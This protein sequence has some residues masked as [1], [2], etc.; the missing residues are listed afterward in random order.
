MNIKLMHLCWLNCAINKFNKPVQIK[1]INNP[2]QSI[3]NSWCRH[4]KVHMNKYQTAMRKSIVGRWKQHKSWKEIWKEFPLC[5][6]FI[7]ACLVKVTLLIPVGGHCNPCPCKARTHRIYTPSWGME[8]SQCKPLCHSLA[9]K[10][11]FLLFWFFHSS[12]CT[13]EKAPHSVFL[14]LKSLLIKLLKWVLTH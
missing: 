1:N 12:S 3:Q 8:P 6:I 14:F 10:P 5:W 11:A 4:I 2:L 9:I 7:D 13:R